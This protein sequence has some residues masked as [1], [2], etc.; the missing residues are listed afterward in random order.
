MVA[1]K[2]DDVLSFAWAA[3]AFKNKWCRVSECRH[4]CGKRKDREFESIHDKEG[5][6]AMMFGGVPAS[7][8]YGVCG[9]ACDLRSSRRSAVVV[10]AMPV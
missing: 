10:M 3:G 7:E 9:L 1:S 5:T 2:E 4:Q 8:I 6:E